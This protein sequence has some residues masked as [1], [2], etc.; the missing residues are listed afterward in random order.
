MAIQ[1]FSIHPVLVLYLD[2]DGVLHHEQVLWSAK[3]GIYMCPRLAP[4]RSL[5]EWAHYLIEA[6]D[7]FP[8]AQLVL[9]SS[10]C[11]RP[12][13]GDTM[14]RLPASLRSRFVGGTFH[15]RV[16]G[17]DSWS[18]TQ[19]LALSRGEQVLQDVKRR[20]PGQWLALDDND[21]GWPPEALDNLIKCDGDTGLSSQRVRDELKFKLKRCNDALL[22][23]SGDA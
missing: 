20:E 21:E 5:F 1:K 23:A 12:G 6:L 9:S 4:G 3:R 8:Q 17:A 14:K 18:V 2:L 11:R 13:F 10:W 19:F 15:K 22:S 7:P 16:H